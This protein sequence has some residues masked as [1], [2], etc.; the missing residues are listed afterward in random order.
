MTAHVR[1]GL[2]SSFNDAILLTNW[3]YANSQTAKLCIEQPLHWSVHCL[4][5][6][7]YLI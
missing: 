2:A 5:E 3:S 6:T 4:Y 1:V 7:V